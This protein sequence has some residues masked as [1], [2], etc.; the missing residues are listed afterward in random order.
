MAGAGATVSVS[1]FIEVRKFTGKDGEEKQ[2]MTVQ[3]ES[4]ETLQVSSG[5]A[6]EDDDPFGNE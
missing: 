3:V 5:P 2:S 6:L 1:G 4:L